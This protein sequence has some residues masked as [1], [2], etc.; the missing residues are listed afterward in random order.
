[1][2]LVAL[3][4]VERQRRH[5]STWAPCATPRCDTGMAPTRHLIGYDAVG[6]FSRGLAGAAGAGAGASFAAGGSSDGPGGAAG[7]G[8]GGGAAGAGALRGAG[9]GRGAGLG[10]AGAGR[11]AGGGVACGGA[12]VAVAGGGAVKPGAVASVVGGAGAAADSPASMPVAGEELDCETSVAPGATPKPPPGCCTSES[13]SAGAA[14][15]PG[16]ALGSPRAAR[17]RTPATMRGTAATASTAATIIVLRRARARREGLA[18]LRF[19]AGGSSG[20]D[21]ARRSGTMLCGPPA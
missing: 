16:S 9:R 14:T 6:G 10:A 7:S 11:A 18:S 15:I 13:G 20:S 4:A 12:G 3:R 1:M 5:A 17:W 8:A 21:T 2:P 19:A